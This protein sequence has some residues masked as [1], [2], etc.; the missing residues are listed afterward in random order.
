MKIKEPLLEVHWVDAC[1][2]AGWG[3]QQYHKNCLEDGLNAHTV[4]YL[5]SETPDAI[6]LAQSIA[7]DTDVNATLCIPKAWIKDRW[8]IK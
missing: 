5:I 6:I 8:V 1:A 3:S 7:E 4:G 2:R